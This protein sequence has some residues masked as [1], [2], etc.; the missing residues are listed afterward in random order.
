MSF[1]TK[2]EAIEA[3]NTWKGRYVAPSTEL[4]RECNPCNSCAKVMEGN[5][6]NQ[7]RDEELVGSTQMLPNGAFTTPWPLLSPNQAHA[8]KSEEF[9]EFKLQDVFALRARWCSLFPSIIE[10]REQITQLLKDND[11]ENKLLNDK[12]LEWN[13]RLE[14]LELPLF[15]HNDLRGINLGGLELA[16]EPYDG[17]WLRNID[18]KFSELSLA[19]LNGANLYNADLRAI[20]AMH[21]SFIHTISSLANFSHSFLS[22]SRF[23]LSDLN[24]A[25]LDNSLC[26]KAQFDGALL[27]NAS[28]CDAMLKNTSFKSIEFVDQG[29]SKSKAT[30][31]IGLSW[32]VGTELD[33]S[34]LL[35]CGAVIDDELKEYL[36]LDKVEQKKFLSRLYDSVQ[37]KPGM[38]GVGIDIKALFKKKS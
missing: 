12:L 4:F 15:E 5:R 8:L 2:E 31:L 11:R 37:L 38:F 13:S 25:N 19:Q 34:D 6:Y 32:N 28:I 16:G 10:Y 26:Y 17:I 33:D 21:G 7:P 22:Q 30:S 18:L 9:S 20:T 27:N 35:T 36:S 29:I 24:S 23:E 1:E 14:E 3:W